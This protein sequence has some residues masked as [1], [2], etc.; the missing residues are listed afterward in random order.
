[1]AG[2][3]Q[4]KISPGGQT[5][6]RAALPQVP[7]GL[8]AAMKLCRETRVKL[9]RGNQAALDVSHHVLDFK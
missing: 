4:T 8:E 5:A 7:S 2:K 3:G 1:M 6:G 9:N